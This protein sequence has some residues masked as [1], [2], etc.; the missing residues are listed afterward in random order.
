MSGRPA[1]LRGDGKSVLVLAGHGAPVDHVLGRLAH[2]VGVVRIG[3]ARV[4][5]TPA[6]GRVE[7]RLLPAREGR[8]GLGHHERGTSHRFDASRHEQV[9]IAGGDRVSGRNDRLHPRPA[10]AVDRLPADLDRHPG[11]QRGHASHVAVVLTGLVGGAQDDVVHGA[12]VD[13]GPIQQS[14]DDVRRQVVGSDRGQGPAVAAEGCAQA[15]DDDGGV[16]R[17]GRAHQAPM[18]LSSL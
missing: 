11:Q 15:I 9:A 4:G 16:D 14:E 3:E 7:Q 6:E 8:R 10:Q 18:L 13:A 5:E 1:L 12:G 17:I 2:R